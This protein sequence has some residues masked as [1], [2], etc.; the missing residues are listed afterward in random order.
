MHRP[1]ITKIVMQNKNTAMQ[2]DL[3]DRFVRTAGN[4]SWL[5]EEIVDPLNRN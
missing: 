4:A 5:K 2:M 1:G 3:V